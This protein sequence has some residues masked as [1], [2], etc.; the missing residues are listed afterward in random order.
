MFMKNFGLIVLLLIILF[1]NIFAG[2]MSID[3]KDLEIEQKTAQ[4]S[5]QSDWL[6]VDSYIDY[7]GTTELNFVDEQ[8]SVT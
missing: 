1:S 7:I 2:S 6:N 4:F 5:Q 8:K 3:E